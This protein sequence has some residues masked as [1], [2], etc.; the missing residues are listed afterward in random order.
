MQCLQLPETFRSHF[1]SLVSRYTACEANKMFTTLPVWVDLNTGRKIMK[2]RRAGIPATRAVPAQCHRC[3]QGMGTALCSSTPVTWQGRGAP[4]PL[5]HIQHQREQAGSPQGGT[6][7][8][9]NDRRQELENSYIAWLQI[10]C[11][12]V[13][14]IIKSQLFH[15][16]SC[17]SPPCSLYSPY[18]HNRWINAVAQ[19][20]FSNYRWI[21]EIL[22]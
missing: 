21:Y 2:E 11:Y 8:A 9:N 18:V 19:W 12:I 13:L 1:N 22:K 16:V 3:H 20:H 17:F 14:L 4:D 10:L 15:S 5:A 6:S 7:K